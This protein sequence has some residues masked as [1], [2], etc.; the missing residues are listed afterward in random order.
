MSLFEQSLINHYVFSENSS[1]QILGGAPI[2]ELVN[3][4]SSS[5]LQGGGY[6]TNILANK[7]HLSVPVGLV[8]VS[9]TEYIYPNIK[10]SNLQME[11]S[12][13]NDLVDLVKEEL[14]ET[15]SEKQ[16]HSKS[17]KRAAIILKKNKTKKK[18]KTG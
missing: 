2:T 5:V 15:K 3:T 1:D 9:H 12:S 18:E 6:N 7:K 17:L 4:Q 13:F 11:N 8:M 16:K 14:S 10:F